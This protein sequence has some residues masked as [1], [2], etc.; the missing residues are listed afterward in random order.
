LKFIDRSHLLRVHETV[1]LEVLKIEFLLFIEQPSQAK[2]RLSFGN[3]V[4]GRNLKI[5][6][7]TRET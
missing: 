7:E 6:L 4:L 3:T 2:K 1:H 5:G